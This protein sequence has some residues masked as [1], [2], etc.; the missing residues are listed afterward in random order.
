MKKKHNIRHLKYLTLF[1]ILAH[2]ITAQ[3]TVQVVTKHIEKTFSGS[4][5]LTIEAEKADIEVVTWGG[6]EIK[7]EID[8]IAKH[9]DRRVASNDLE[10]MRYVADKM[11][12]DVFLRNY[13]LIKDEKAKPM[14]NLKAK[15]TVKVPEG[16]KVTI[17]NSFGKISVKGK[18]KLLKIKT[19]FC[20]VEL[21]DGE[22]KTELT[23][24]YGEINTQNINGIMTITSERTDLIINELAGRCSINSQY[25]KI[26]IG[27]LANLKKLTIEAKKS[28]INLNKISLN[29]HAFRLTTTYGKLV[30]PAGFK[31][32]SWLENSDVNKT[33]ILNTTHP[34][35]I[36]I[37]N[38]FGNINLNN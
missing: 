23:T 21:I 14:S 30:L 32:F 29:S 16:M 2:N 10:T 27:G 24:H 36:D 19:D 28:E 12:K 35:K 20:I 3:T 33:A 38:I 6:Q 1:I 17:Q 34:S 8:L 22:G 15:Y 25:G 7:V 11:N 37:V 13:L 9:P 31:E 5:T 18:L 4:Q 26:N